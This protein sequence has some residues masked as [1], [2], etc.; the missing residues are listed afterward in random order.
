[1]GH[2][3]IFQDFAPVMIRDMCDTSKGTNIDWIGGNIVHIM[4]DG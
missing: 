3:I 1:M 4:R 2:D